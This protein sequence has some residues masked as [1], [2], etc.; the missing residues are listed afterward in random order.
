MCGRASRRPPIS[1]SFLANANDDLGGS[2][3][4]LRGTATVTG[5]RLTLDG[6]GGYAELDNRVVGDVG[7]FSVAF[8]AQEGSTRDSYVEFLSQGA[9]GS[10]FYVGHT[11]TGNLRASDAWL[12]TGIPMPQDNLEHHYAVT[13]NAQTNVITLYVDGQFKANRSAPIARGTS[14]G[15]NTRFGRQFDP[16]SSTCRVPSTTSASTPLCS[17]RGT[18]RRSRG[19]PPISPVPPRAP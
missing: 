14:G 11:P 18:S 3:G 2:R 16:S 1:F 4:T 10:G 7:N 9:S 12:D 5:G 17:A 6:M 19:A 13:F 15:N 8:F